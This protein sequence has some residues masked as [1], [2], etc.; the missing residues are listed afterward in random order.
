MGLR[1]EDRIIENFD[2]VGTFGKLNF[3]ESLVTYEYDS[4][5]RRTD[6]PKEQKVVV[7]SENIDDQVEII[8]PA[9]YPTESL[10]YNAE[11]ELTGGVT[12][13]PWFNF[14]EGTNG[15]STFNSAFKVRAGG[16]RAVGAT[17]K[18]APQPV[19]AKQEN[20]Q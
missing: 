1:F 10:E 4:E 16:I 14:D 18:Q 15:F 9:D 3:L 7:Y 6:I 17:A 19:K 8:I 2:V 11:I 12:A 13:S 20:K 5:N